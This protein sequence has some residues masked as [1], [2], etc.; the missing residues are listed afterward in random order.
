MRV[1]RDDDDGVECVLDSEDEDS[2]MEVDADGVGVAA[3]G[4]ATASGADLSMERP[5]VSGAGA[6]GEDLPLGP[7]VV[8]PD[9]ASGMDLAPEVAARLKEVL[10]NM[11]PIYYEVFI[12][13]S[14][15]FLEILS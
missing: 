1:A 6:A 12:S 2:G 4:A 8:A 7:P 5:P 11:D 14:S 3:E 10:A 13:M 9:D 15:K